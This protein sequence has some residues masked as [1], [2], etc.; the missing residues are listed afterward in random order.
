MFLAELIDFLFAQPDPLVHFM[1][2][3]LPKTA[4]WMPSKVLTFSIWTPERGHPLQ[5][6]IDGCRH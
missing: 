1:L 3:V 4:C 6:Q 2:V 5:L